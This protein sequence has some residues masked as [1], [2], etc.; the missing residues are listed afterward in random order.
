[1]QQVVLEELRLECEVWRHIMVDESV[2][3]GS[4]AWLDVHG[5]F[6]CGQGL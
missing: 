3:V 2:P 6:V 1:M 4:E 5:R